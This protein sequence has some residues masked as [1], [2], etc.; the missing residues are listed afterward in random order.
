MLDNCSPSLLPVLHE[1]VQDLLPALDHSQ[2]DG[3]KLLFP[4]LS[5]LVK[6]LGK[7][8]PPPESTE[9]L[10]LTFMSESRLHCGNMA[11]EIK[12]FLQGHIQQYRLARG[13]MEE[14]DIEDLLPPPD[15]A[16]EEAKPPLAMHMKISKEVAEKCTHFLSHSDPQIRVQALDTLR[17][18]LL[19]IHSQEDV[20]LPLAHKIWPCLVKRLLQDE[21]LVLLRAF[22]VLVS[23]A[24]SCKDFL[25]QRVC[26]DALPA[27][28]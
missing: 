23:L 13:E 8:F 18:S 6:R 19:P 24:S 14:G 3:A 1:L 17:L 26:K 22:Q 25:Q 12:E 20:L 2:N 11:H 5:S 16:K 9:E 28:L 15:E 27:F 4:V 10:P 21:P 7:W